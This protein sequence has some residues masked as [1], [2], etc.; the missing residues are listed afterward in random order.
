M[1]LKKRRT[2][3]D[4]E[5]MTALEKINLLDEAIYLRLKINAG[6]VKDLDFPYNYL[7]DV[8]RSI[9]GNIGIYLTE[10]MKQDKRMQIII[11]KDAL[12]DMVERAFIRFGEQPNNID[13]I[14]KELKSYKFLD[15]II[16]R[17]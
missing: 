9:R 17:R 16:N 13:E 3:K 7:L 4:I 8:L 11:F 5:N 15:D 1:A 2:L 14:V 12:Y 10:Y 6:I